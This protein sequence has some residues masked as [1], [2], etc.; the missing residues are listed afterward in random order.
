MI[1]LTSGRAQPVPHG[2]HADPQPPLRDE[3]A[4]RREAVP[5]VVCIELGL[6]WWSRADTAEV[7]RSREGT[8]RGQD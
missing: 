3:G 6:S 2:E 8:E 7:L 1:K 5:V 4:R